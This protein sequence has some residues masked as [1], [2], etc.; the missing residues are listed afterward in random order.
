MRS[1]F[2]HEIQFVKYRKVFFSISIILVILSIVGLLLRGVN[3]GIEFIG[4]TQ[5]SFNDTGS[6]T[7]SEMRQ[8]FADQGVN[9]ATVQTSDSNGTSGFLVGTS[10]TDPT[11]ASA[12]ADS[13][14]SALGLASDSYTVTTI[15]P[16][17][18]SDVTRSMIIAFVVVIALIILFVSIRYEFKMSLMGVLSLIQVLVIVAGVYAWTQ[19]EVTPNVVAALLTIMGFVLYDTVVVFNRVNENIRTYRDATHRTALQITNL[20]ENQ[21]IIR[22]INTTLTSLMPVIAMLIFGGDTLKNFAFAMLIGLAFGAYS[23]IALAAPLYALWKTREPEWKRAEEL[24]GEKAQARGKVIDASSVQ[25]A[26]AAG[27]SDGSESASGQAAG[28]NAQAGSASATSAVSGTQGSSKVSGKAKKS[29]Y[30]GKVR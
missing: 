30:S 3:L 24:Y 22:S 9:D 10:E 20:A 13:V 18:G 26:G 2:S 25:T 12:L 19:Y 28:T 17:W 6:I 4:G 1:H 7:L 27:D 29:K 14:A 5:I 11:A 15:G 21:V 16:N 8:A 23:S